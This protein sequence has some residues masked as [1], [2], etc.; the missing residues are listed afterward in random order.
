MKRAEWIES[1]GGPLLF[2]PRSIVAEWRGSDPGAAQGQP[3]DYER[4]C[5]VGEEIAAILVGGVQALILGDEPDRT[6]LISR[7]PSN[8]LILR[9]RWARSEE[10]LL[11]SLNLEE[12]DR[13]P[14]KHERTFEAL[15]DEYLL[16]D[17][18]NSGT[19]IAR[20][21][22]VNMTAGTCSFDALDFQP[23]AS[24]FAMI[25]RLRINGRK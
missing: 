10:S 24:I 9:W 12:V 7:S 19:A 2:A 13:L 15:T 17:S 4:A 21:L 3:T 20:A 18:A 14:T 8:V 22:S 6:T 16:F 25:H 11:S 5:A 23:D 1:G